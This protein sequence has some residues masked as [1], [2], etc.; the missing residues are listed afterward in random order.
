MAF[1]VY[2]ITAIIEGLRVNE[3]QIAHNLNLTGGIT[4]SAE[5]KTVLMA[6][7]LEPEK[8]YRLAQELAFQAFSEQCPYLELLLASAEVPDGAKRGALQAC[9]ELA[10]KLQHV[11]AIFARF[12]L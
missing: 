8:A 4:N 6:Q 1:M 11:P 5:V 9:F 12:G 7:G 2:R 3:E 10:P